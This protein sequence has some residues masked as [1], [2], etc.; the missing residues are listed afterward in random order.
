[1]SDSTP[2]TP[3]VGMFVSATRFSDGVE[4]QGVLMSVGQ[5]D[6]PAILYV[7]NGFNVIATKCHNW[8]LTKTEETTLSEEDEAGVVYARTQIDKDGIWVFR[9]QQVA[10]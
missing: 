3:T 1:M 6:E 10:A 9:R 4:V 2:T 8:P 7:P 5:G